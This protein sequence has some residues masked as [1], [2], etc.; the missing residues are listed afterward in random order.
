MAYFS[1]LQR[2]LFFTS[3]RHLSTFHER[4]SL[5]LDFGHNMPQYSKGSQGQDSVHHPTGMFLIHKVMLFGLTS[6][7][8]VF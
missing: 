4:R 7:P 5:F 2:L 3:K 8:S 6:V 1:H